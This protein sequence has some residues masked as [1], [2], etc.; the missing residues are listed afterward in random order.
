MLEKRGYEGLVTNN[1][2]EDFAAFERDRFGLVLLD[3][4]MPVLDSF[5]TTALSD[6][7][8]FNSR[9]CTPLWGIAQ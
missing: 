3:L 2:Q 7:S 4:Q 5:A 1:G 9:N 8:Q 6:Q